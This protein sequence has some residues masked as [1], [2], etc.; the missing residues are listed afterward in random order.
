M[1]RTALAISLLLSSA[2]SSEAPPVSCS[3]W[4]TGVDAGAEPDCRLSGTPLALQVQVA[5]YSTTAR[6][7]GLTGFLDGAAF[8]PVSF[9][10]EKVLRGQALAKVDALVPGCLDQSGVGLEGP[11]GGES[12]YVFLNLVD[13]Y[14]V[15]QHQGWFWRDGAQL[16]NAGAYSAGIDEAQLVS[17]LGGPTP[18]GCG[19]AADGG[20]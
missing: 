8:T 17:K 12:G 5:A 2:C 6:A 11:L 18:S 15:V 16:K 14:Y 4:G 1:L 7:M 10:V 3:R 19:V 20:T 9:K 13:D